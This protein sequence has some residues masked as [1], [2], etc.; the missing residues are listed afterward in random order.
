VIL[1]GFYQRWSALIV[2]GCVH[3]RNPVECS[4]KF[5]PTTPLPS[6]RT[7]IFSI[8]DAHPATHVARTFSRK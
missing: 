4:E 3:R 2:A 7:G 8:R 6:E 1:V 5:T